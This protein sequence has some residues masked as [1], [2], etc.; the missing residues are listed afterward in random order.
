MIDLHQHSIFSDGT[1]SFDELLVKNK[2]AG[3]KVMSVTDHDNI[4]SARCVAKMNKGNLGIEYIHGVE[5][6]TDYEGAS[7]HI[8]AYGYEADDK[9]INELLNRAK[10]LRLQRVKKRIELLKLEF[11]IILDEASLNEIL[12]SKNPGKPLIAN[13]LIRLGYGD[14]ITDVIK[15]YLYHKLP[16]KKLT[17]CEVLKT[18]KNSSAISVLAHPLG[19]IGEKRV[20]RCVF[21]E[22]LKAFVSFGLKGL[23][24]YYSLYT[25]EEQ[26]Y[27]VKIANTYSLLIS[28]GSDYHGKNKDVN[29]GEMLNGGDAPTVENISLIKNVNK[30]II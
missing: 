30:V 3:V 13:V 19:G 14:N 24:C 21:E 26:Q 20:E 29:I 15:K 22:R 10:Q 25:K 11:D 6:S 1:D 23:E 4:E 2:N 16:S 18:L 27:L 7:V 9:S 5:F 28:G 12:S 17:S 8:L